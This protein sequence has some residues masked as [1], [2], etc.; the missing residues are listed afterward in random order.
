LLGCAA[1]AFGCADDL[2]K[3]TDIVHMRVLGAKLQVVGD[4]TRATPKPGEQVKVSFD[5]VFPTQK[6]ST[7][8]SQLMMINCTAPTRFTGGIPICQEFLDAAQGADST[9]VQNALGMEKGKTKVSC[10]DLGGFPVELNGVGLRCGLGE[11]AMTFN[12][13][14]DFSAP[15][16]L[17][18][19]V[20]CEKGTPVLDV[21]DPAL[22]TCEHDSGETI[23]LN[24][25]I[26]IQH[27][28]SEVNHNPSL[29][30]FT[31]VMDPYTK[32]W[33]VPENLPADNDCRGQ[34][35]PEQTVPLTLPYADPGTHKLLLSYE[36]A[37]REKHDGEPETLELT[38]Y[39]T[40]GEME[41]RFTLWAP[42]DPT[43]KGKLEA[44]LDWDPPGVDELP[45]SGKLVRFFITVRDQRGGFDSSE[46][47]A[48]V[49]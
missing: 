27:D 20:L 12:V 40:G 22:F 37:A 45:S 19:G 31:I 17:F 5:T 9:D 39:T 46:R 7:K 41:R 26:T 13:R 35:Q 18:L 38:I 10:D 33:L 29:A 4:E 3:A 6:G 21:N 15:R 32:P 28:K 16:M 43:H 14:K 47:A 2:P 36:A 11:P 48:C 49:H 34:E 23:R 8:N 30:D 25:L 42:D 44:D 1:L 24:G